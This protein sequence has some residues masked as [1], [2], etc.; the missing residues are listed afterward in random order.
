MPTREQLFAD[1]VEFCLSNPSKLSQLIE[2]PFN[3]GETAR[4]DSHLERSSNPIA[5]EALLVLQLHRGELDAAAALV[6]SMK[7]GQKH[8]GVEM[9][10]LAKG[11]ALARGKA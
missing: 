11:I 4:L 5:K 7:S 10:D 1:M 9:S 2:L 8:A 3:E 6:G